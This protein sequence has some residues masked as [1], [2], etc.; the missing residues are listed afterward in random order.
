MTFEATRPKT[1]VCAALLVAGALIASVG[2][3][4]TDTS[5]PTVA[6]SG[7]GTTTTTIAT[8]T[9]TKSDKQ[10]TTTNGSGIAS[11][12][13]K[14]AAQAALITATDVPDGF[15]LTPSSST[16]SPNPFLGVD[17]CAPYQKAIKATDDNRTAK[18]K[19]DFKNA[20]KDDIE[21]GVEVYTEAKI[22]KDAADALA[23]SGFPG[24]IEAAFKAALKTSM[25]TD[26]SIDSVKASKGDL[27]SAS[28][29]GLDS[30]IAYNLDIAFTI[31]GQ[32][33]TLKTTF[34]L[35]SSGRSVAQLTAQGTSVVDLG[36]A[37][38]AAA[39]KLKANAPT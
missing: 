26:A 16:E 33:V 22:A 23:D 35:L 14:K 37:V 31:K 24:C 13:D 38:Q 36:T 7:S 27:K 20:A 6:Q 34:I 25:P 29:L 3:S 1:F 5:Q 19:V 4:K 21:E 39:D 28:D 11:A 2:C 30:A 9:T 15:A 18:V 17:E 10:T 12:E 8:T 32:S